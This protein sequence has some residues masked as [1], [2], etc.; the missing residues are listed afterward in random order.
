MLLGY[1]GV[2][3]VDLSGFLAGGDGRF[4]AGGAVAPVDDLGLV[5]GEAE[6]VVDLQAGSVAGRAV[7]VDHPAAVAAHQVV[8][9]VV[10]PVLVAGRERAGWIRR[11]RPLSA[12]TPRAS[13]T[14]CRDTD[15]MLARTSP[16]R[17]SAV[18]WGRAD[19]AFS[20]ASR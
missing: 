9:V 1:W 16:M 11:I 19:T 13:N 18:A 17:S 10:N 8:V 5:D 6:V 15:P 4:L 2:D 14:A 20:T 3:G 12:S 7:D